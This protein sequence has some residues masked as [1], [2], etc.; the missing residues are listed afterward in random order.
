MID[1]IIILLIS[2][3]LVAAVFAAAC[4]LAVAHLYLNPTEVILQCWAEYCK[5][6]KVPE[7]PKYKKVDILV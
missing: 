5:E 7:Q 1:F 2:A 4:F 3:S 6:Q